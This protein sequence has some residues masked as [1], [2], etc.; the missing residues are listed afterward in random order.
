MTLPITPAPNRERGWLRIH[1]E[2][3]GRTMVIRVWQARVGKVMLYLLD[4]NDPDQ[5]S[6]QA[7]VLTPTREL[8]IQVADAIHGY[9]GRRVAVDWQPDY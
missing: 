7:L 3:P 2:L 6:V 1:L 5:A 8:A 4:S 9:A